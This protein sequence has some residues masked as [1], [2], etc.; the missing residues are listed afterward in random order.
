MMM[1]GGGGGAGERER[2]SERERER[3]K[4]RDPQCHIP[5]TCDERASSSWSREAWR[6]CRGRKTWGRRG[7]CCQEM[8]QMVEGMEL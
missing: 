6:D 7:N 2:E 3:E 4:L 1:I 8:Y 5:Y